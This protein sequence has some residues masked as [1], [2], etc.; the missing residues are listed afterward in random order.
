MPKAK[1]DLSTQVQNPELL[2]LKK[3]AEKLLSIWQKPIVKTAEQFESAGQGAKDIAL[4]RRDLKAKIKPIV[5]AA[6][7]DYDEKRKAYKAVDDIL[8][9][10][11]DGIRNALI[12]Y[13][14]MHKKAAEVKVEKA[15]AE[16]R[17][18]KAAAIAAKPYIPEVQGL[19][20]TERWHGEVFDMT[21]FV[22]AW[23]GGK[24]PPESLCVDMV[25]LN[26]K[27]RATKAEDIGVPGARGV[28]ETSSG[29]RT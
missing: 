18:E 3:K 14:D 1:K 17:D 12:A 19:S 28:K 7:A 5:D 8:D 15:L 23:L 21:L 10:S 24:L 29:V 11:E 13:N 25:W 20:F 22:K 6:K 26:T 4:V 16:G 2:A 9:Q 27:A